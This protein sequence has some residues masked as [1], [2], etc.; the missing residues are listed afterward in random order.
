M[1]YH[2]MGWG[3]WTLMAIGMVTFWALVVWLVAT[4][5]REGPQKTATDTEPLTASAE[6]ILAERY[7]RG[8]IDAD[9]YHRLLEDLRGGQLSGSRS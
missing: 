3:A 9:D 6:R 4:L 8:D 5:V 1:W 2:N 7:A